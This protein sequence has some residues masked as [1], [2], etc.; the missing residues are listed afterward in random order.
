MDNM[1]AYIDSLGGDV[2]PNTGGDL[3]S[4]ALRCLFALSESSGSR[5]ERLAMVGGAF[6]Q[7]SKEDGA[8]TDLGEDNSLE[9]AGGGSSEEKGEA[10]ALI[11]AL[12]AFLGRC[13]RDSSEQY[14]VS[15]SC[16]CMHSR[17]SRSWPVS[18]TSLLLLASLTNLS[19]AH[20]D[21][22]RVSSITYPLVRPYSC[23]T[24][25]RSPP[26]TSVP[27]P[28]RTAERR[29]SAGSSAR[30]PAATSWS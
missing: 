3:P 25:S 28:S 29:R 7:I 9:V 19:R 13:P 14:L 18:L 17:H 16:S 12:L 20:C 26:R 24:T 15:V 6:G 4:R 27:S 8:A 23:S 22:S 2:S 5:A 11:P 1:R 10:K 21:S 30:T